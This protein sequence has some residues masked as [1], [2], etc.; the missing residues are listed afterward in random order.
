V[1]GTAADAVAA[2]A[3]E[4]VLILREKLDHGVVVGV[5]WVGE[6]KFVG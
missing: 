6:S 1:A 2:V 3:W 5:A 4:E